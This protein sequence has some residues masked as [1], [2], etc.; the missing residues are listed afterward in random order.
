M[1][2]WKL[3]CVLKSAVTQVIGFKIAGQFRWIDY[4]AYFISWINFFGWCFATLLVYLGA[5][6]SDSYSSD[7]AG[8]NGYSSFKIKL[9]T[10]I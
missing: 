1:V 5:V 10:V 3:C 6:C 9:L 4:F 7:E 2:A 8:D